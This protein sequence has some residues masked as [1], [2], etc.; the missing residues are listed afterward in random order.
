[1]TK[2]FLFLSP[3][4]RVRGLWRMTWSVVLLLL[5]QAG[6]T[7]GQTDEEIEQVFWQSVECKSARQV[8]A[9][10]EVYPTGRYLAEAWGC[11]EGQLDLERA[12]RILVQRGLA[13]L[14]YSAGV[15]DGLF[16][17]ATRKAIRA[18]QT[19]KEF[20]AT[21]YLTREQADALIAQGREAAA[22]A[23]RQRRAEGQRRAEAER[24][25][26]EEEARRQAAEAERQRQ[27]Q[28]AAERA[29]A[30]Q[31][32]RTAAKRQEFP[33]EFT[34]SVGIEFVLIEPGTFQMGSPATEPGWDDSE[35]PVHTVTISKPFYLGKYEVTQEQWQ[36]VM[37]DNPSYFSD[38]G[39]TCPVESVSW[40]DV[41]GFI[42]ELNLREGV[43]LYRLPT[44]AEWEYAARGGTQTAYSFGAGAGRLRFYG[45]YGG[46]SERRT[47]P[48]GEKRPNAFGLYD[49]HGNVWEWV[50]DCWNENYAGAPSD[51]RA[52]E[53][54]DCSLRVL[55]GGSAGSYPRGLR[56]ADRELNSADGRRGG[57]GF[58]LARSLP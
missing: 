34:N 2:L 32:A 15:A 12:E 49:I 35:G 43:Q 39:T 13:T 14:D 4:S 55:R 23:E 37:G 54:G 42:E 57:R 6:P 27:A 47:H 46:N 11:L 8:Q 21:G 45:W 36:V 50:R 44:E 16:G 30:E 1:M 18:W 20:A 33:R 56:S 38:C 17:P 52:W 24:K 22:A 31:Q 25:R 7:I 5:V 40:E 29:K 28:E 3:S 51:G 48:V 9:Y 53:S 41:Q 58:R 19:A 26:Q 10:L